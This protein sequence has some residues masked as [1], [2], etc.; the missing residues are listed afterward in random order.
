MKKYLKTPVHKLILQQVPF[1][2]FIRL[3]GSRVTV[4]RSFVRFVY[5]TYVLEIRQHDEPKTDRYQV[6]LYRRVKG[7]SEELPA[8]NTGTRYRVVRRLEN[9]RSLELPTAIS[10]VSG[11]TVEQ[12]T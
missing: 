11:L 1:K 4:G 9:C 3:T 7:Q 12:Y 6:T 2:Q 5:Q 10:R 8:N